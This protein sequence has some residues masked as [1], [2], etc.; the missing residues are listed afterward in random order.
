MPSETTYQVFRCEGCL[1]VTYCTDDTTPQPLVAFRRP[2]QIFVHDGRLVGLYAKSDTVVTLLERPEHDA[3]RILH[4]IENESPVI[5][6]NGY[7]RSAVI[8][9]SFL[10]P[11][12][13]WAWLR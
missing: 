13:L 4:A 9:L 1:F 7:I 10:T 6:L 3:A 12:V 5:I 8:L 11:L 2:E